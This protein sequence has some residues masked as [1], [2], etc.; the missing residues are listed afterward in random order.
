MKIIKLQRLI[1]ICFFVIGIFL[2]TAYL[3]GFECY[4]QQK[5]INDLDEAF[6]LEDIESLQSAIEAI[7]LI[8]SE[9]N[10][11][12][13]EALKD[14]KRHKNTRAIIA[15]KLGELR[16]SE[17]IE[18]LRVILEDQKEP[19][20]IRYAAAK[21]LGKMKREEALQPLLN[22]FLDEKEKELNL[23]YVI[24]MS[25]RDNKETNAIEA[26][27]KTLENDDMMLRYKAAQVLGSLEDPRAIGPLEEVLRSDPNKFVKKRAAKSLQQI[28]GI[29]YNDE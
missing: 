11:D 17:A 2:F 16:G 12:L 8:G 6:K 22:V 5:Y 25:F 9:D 3:Q 7:N 14:K 24:A 20:E 19:K 21:A 15:K 27:I 1:L 10:K 23:K 28:T 29:I 13:I 18:P 4:A 26:L